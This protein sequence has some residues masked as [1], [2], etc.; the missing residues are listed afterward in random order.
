MKAL[1]LKEINSFFSSLIGY[2]VILVFLVFLGLFMWVFPSA[3]FNILDGGYANIDTLFV[4]SPWV[5]MFLI[6]AITMRSIAEELR[7]GTFEIL[8][9]KP[10]ST[11]NIVLSKYFAGVILVGVALIPTLI[12][13][14][15]VHLLGDPIG[16][17][18]YGGT[19]G[20]YLGLF[21]L[22]SGFVAIGIFASS[23]TK[24]QIISFILAVFISFVIYVG[25]E[26]LAGLFDNGWLENFILKLGINDHFISLSRGVIDSRD[27]MYFLSLTF[28]FLWLTTKKIESLR[29]G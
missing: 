17:L 12:F 4:I 3:E 6:P 18:D 29:F 20:S 14:I 25:F 22:A 15:S 16:N 7:T 26:S 8:L 13:L 28:V 23:L 1:L 5:F 21:F 19:I 11:W 27:L 2:I 24:N 10:L 9:T